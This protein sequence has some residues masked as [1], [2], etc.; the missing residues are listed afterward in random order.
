MAEEMIGTPFVGKEREELVEFLKEQGLDYDENIS[1]SIVLREDGKIIA[2]GS[3]HQNILKCI[4]VAKECQGRNLL[5]PV[6]SNLTAHFFETGI[7]HFFGFTKPK[8]KVIFTKMGLYPIAE[9]GHVLLL[10]NKKDGIKKYLDALQ[11]ETQMQMETGQ[12][13]QK[14]TQIGSIVANC[15]PFTKGHRYLIEEAAKQCKW[16]HLFILSEEQSDF[17]T[18]ERW[19]MV[20]DGIYDIPNV[21]LHHTSDYLISPVVFPTYFMKEKEKAYQM[22]CELDIEIFTSLIAPGLQIDCRYVGC[23]PDCEVTRAYNGCLKELLPSHKIQVYELERLK[24]HGETVSASKVRAAWKKGML[25]D[26]DEMIPES[27]RQILEEIYERKYGKRS[28]A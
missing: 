7:T 4:A 10:E 5:A 8:N 14:K 13:N 15:N 12:E 23:E 3:C 9:T 1:Y 21:I 27:T 18:A 25:E 2:T 22:N 16:L 19:K 6:L 20:L 11:K 28:N 24:I 17:T 26:A